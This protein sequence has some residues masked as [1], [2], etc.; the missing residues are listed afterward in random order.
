MSYTRCRLGHTHWGRY[1]AAG[2]LVVDKGKVLLQ[3]RPAGVHEGGRWSVPG[4]ALNHDERPVDAAL[5]EA[6]EET[7]IAPATVC[8]TS[9]WADDCGGGWTYSTF[10]AAVQHWIRGPLTHAGNF[11][12]EQLEWVPLDEVAALPLHPA[13]R[14][15]WPALRDLARDATNA[16]ISRITDRVWTGGDCGGQPMRSYLAQL[17][18]VGITHIIDCRPEG[19]RDQRT[20]Q[21]HAPHIGY[22]LNGQDDNGQKMPDS[23]FDTGVDFALKALADPAQVLAHCHMGIAR[24]P[25]MALAILLAQGMDADDALAAIRRARPVAEINYARDAIAWWQRRT[26]TPRKAATQ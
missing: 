25:S 16:N 14:R 21:T 10:V 8:I 23:W 24:G 17:E 19:T 6:G 11:E 9:G 7:G 12:S 15:S 3:L 2:L 18:S 22:L 13:F 1:G 20:A 5:R 26:S 4:G